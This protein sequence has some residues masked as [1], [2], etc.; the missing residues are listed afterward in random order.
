ML[1]MPDT[2]S[3]SFLD[4]AVCIS[5]RVIS[6]DRA[7]ANWTVGPRT[8][9]ERCTNLIACEVCHRCRHH[10]VICLLCPIEVTENGR[11][12]T[13]TCHYCAIA[14]REHVVCTSC[15]D[16][17][18]RYNCLDCQVGTCCE[19]RCDEIAEEEEDY[20]EAVGAETKR[21]PSISTTNYCPLCR[22]LF[23]N[24]QCSHA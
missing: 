18:L 17:R 12:H 1:V 23:H 11:Q 15:G 2:Q 20:T 5:R 7:I 4:R 21:I 19:C 6:Y 13:R 14:E 9:A 24:C 10:T 22:K 8:L 3:W 16:C